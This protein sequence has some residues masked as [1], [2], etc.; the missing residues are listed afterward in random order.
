M[1]NILKKNKA[2]SARTGILKTNHGDIKTPFFMPIATKGVVKGMSADDMKD[3]EAQILLSNTYHLYLR[4]GLDLIKKASGLH[5]FMNWDGPI[6][7]DSGG[8][9][10]FSLCKMRKLDEQGVTFRSHIDGGETILTPEDSIKAQITFGSD[11]AM[12]LDECIPYPSEYSYVK[13][14]V[15]LTTRWAL[16]CKEEFNNVKSKNKL[17][18]I[19]QGSIYEDLR[20]KSAKDL[21]KIGFDGYAIGG[22]AVGEPED[23][24]LEVLDY[25]TPHL[26]EGKPRYLMGEGTPQGILEAI[27]R[28]MDMFDCVIPT[29]NARHGLLYTDLN[30]SGL[31]KIEFKSVRIK[32]E[33]YKEDLSSLDSRCNCHTCENYSKAYLRHLFMMGDYLGQRLATIHNIS[34]YMKMMQKIRENI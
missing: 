29:R 22:L 24:K 33:K 8:Y 28:G 3:L 1:F 6:L 18:G 12:A 17:F 15:E 31:E 2:T 9:Q 11:I 21:I 14:S 20:K 26:P 30:L 32:N 10:V 16:R 5:K 13:D 7:T 23:K 27:K 19:V 34:F 4:P 25:T